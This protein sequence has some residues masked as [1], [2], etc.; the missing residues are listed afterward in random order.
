MVSAHSCASSQLASLKADAHDSIA[1]APTQVTFVMAASRSSKPLVSR[2][3]RAR[4]D[5]EDEDSI[6]MVEDSQ[7]EGSVQSEGDEADADGSD[8]SETEATETRHED[9]VGSLADGNDKEPVSGSKK[10]KKAEKPAQSGETQATL[11]QQTP[12]TPSVDTEAMLNGLEISEDKDHETAIDFEK[13]GAGTEQ[14][15]KPTNTPTLQQQDQA[16]QGKPENIIDRRRRE[17]EEYKK[18]RDSD[19]TFIPN[20][21]NFF[22]HD[23]RAPDQRGFTSY[24]RGRGRGRGFIGGPFSPAV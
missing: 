13:M 1:F 9:A 6:T 10:S 20:R 2:R 19:P 18:K 5:S 17:H 14:D 23:A 4:R 11:E 16:M 3:R 24:G 21:G 7:S 12:F 22:M 15:L 8:L